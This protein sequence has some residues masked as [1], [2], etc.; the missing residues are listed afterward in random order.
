MGRTML[1]ALLRH[2]TFG[3]ITQ[4]DLASSP[5]LVDFG[6]HDEIV[7]REAANR[8]RIEFNAQLLV[9]CQV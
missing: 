6:G 2:S 5:E 8:V 3:A 4:K 7:L 1:P 9:S